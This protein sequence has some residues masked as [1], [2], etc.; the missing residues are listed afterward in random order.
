MRRMA[1]LHEGRKE[2][3]EENISLPFSSIT[4]IIW[5]IEIFISVEMPGE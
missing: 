4:V 3:R 1:F 5:L 2:R